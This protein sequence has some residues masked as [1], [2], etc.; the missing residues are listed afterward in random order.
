[1]GEHTFQI[2]ARLGNVEA[3]QAFTLTVLP[4]ITLS[5]GDEISGWKGEP[6]LEILTYQG[7]SAVSQWFL[8]GAPPGVEIAELTCPGPYEGTHQTVAI[9][10]KPE[11]GGRF[12]ATVIAHVCFN[13]LPEIHRRPITFLIADELYVP[14]LHAQRL[15]YDLQFQIR[16]GLANRKVRSFYAVAAVAEEKAEVTTKETVPGKEITTTKTAVTPGRPADI[17]TVKRGDRVTLAILPRDGRAVLASADGISDVAIA[18][19]LLESSD[20][21]YLFAL[22]ATP[23]PVDDH[24]YFGV[25]LEVT[26]DLLTDLMGDDGILTQPV[27][28]AAELRCNLNGAEIS[29]ETFTIQIAEDV[30]Q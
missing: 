8:V 26:S 12:D 29:S 6:I 24:E 9:G 16:G 11:L 19:R 13:G 23:V 2:A 28:V 1:V 14:W 5:G 18:M 21:E 15:L 4:I 10:G 27:P 22:P 30:H 25:V 17:L 20:A 7:E 3:T